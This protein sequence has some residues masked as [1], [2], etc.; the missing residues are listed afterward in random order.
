MLNPEWVTDG[1]YRVLNDTPL[2]R[3][4]PRGQLT[5]SDLTRILPAARWPEK[6]YHYL[7]K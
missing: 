6:W 1:I 4:A 3:A 5:F 2:P 7:V